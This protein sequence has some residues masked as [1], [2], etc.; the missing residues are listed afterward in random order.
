MRFFRK[1]KNLLVKM[2]RYDAAAFL[3]RTANML[4]FLSETGLVESRLSIIGMMRPNE[5]E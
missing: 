4:D 5:Y 1:F 2:R 3:I